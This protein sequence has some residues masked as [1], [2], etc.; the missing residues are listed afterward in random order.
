MKLYFTLWNVFIQDGNFDELEVGKTFTDCSFELTDL[1]N[2]SKS[3]NTNTNTEFKHIK[4]NHYH[5]IGYIYRITKYAIF[6]EV[7]GLLL[8]ID[9][10]DEYNIKNIGYYE[11]DGYLNNDM[12]NYFGLYEWNDD[13]DAKHSDELELTGIIKSIQIDTSLYIQMGER[14]WSKKGVESKYSVSVQKTNCWDDEDN[15][16]NGSFNYLVELEIDNLKYIRRK[17]LYG[18][19]NLQGLKL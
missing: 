11:F 9:N 12:W 17:F 19:Q 4:E 2:I 10:R 8:N 15:Y 7:A 16:T 3:K 1:E 13:N 5:I 14:S 18:M 6:I